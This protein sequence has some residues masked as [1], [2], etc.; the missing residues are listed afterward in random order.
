MIANIDVDDIIRKARVYADQRESDFIYDT[1]GLD[2][3]QIG[4]DA[5]YKQIV[6][7]VENFF[8]KVVEIKAEGE[9]L[10]LPDDFYKL[11]LLRLNISEDR[12]HKMIPLKLNQIESHEGQGVS[13]NSL[14][15]SNNVYYDA[16]YILLKDTIRLVPKNRT[17]DRMFEMYYVPETEKLFLN[18]QLEEENTLRTETYT[19]A[20]E[21]YNQQI[22]DG[23][24]PNTLE[25]PEEPVLLE[26]PKLPTSISNYL[27]YHTA[28]DIGIAENISESRLRRRQSKWEGMI[29][30]WAS[31]RNLDYAKTVTEDEDESN[32]NEGLYGH[33]YNGY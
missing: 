26:N 7:K 24:D 12:K 18:S 9:F 23:V 32:H 22:S 28:M 11:S 27:V 13:I 21:E 17:R 30:D 29:L 31:S 33:Y 5:I 6:E 4:Y 8:V 25:A 20:L 3:V 14:L 2:I 15:F 19:T 16:G 1:E 10:K